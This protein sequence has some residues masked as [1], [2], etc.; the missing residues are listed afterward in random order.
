MKSHYRAFAPA[1][2]L[3]CWG[4]KDSGKIAHQKIKVGDIEFDSFAEHDRYL[5][6]TMMER[7]GLIHDI[8]CH[9][10]YECLPSQETPDGRQNFRPVV[11]TPDF[12]Y[13]TADG[14]TVVEEVKSEYSRHEKDYVIRRKLLYYTQG[15][16]VEELVR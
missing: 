8:E 7:A 12:R 10:S 3:K 16:Y 2:Q 4:E 15:I 5:E 9:P 11:Y 1:V 6:L 13:V 14:R